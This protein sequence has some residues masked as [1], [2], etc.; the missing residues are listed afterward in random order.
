METKPS[1]E[2]QQRITNSFEERQA[3]YAREVKRDLELLRRTV[4]AA[5][6]RE[7]AKRLDR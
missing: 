3:L 4:K 2:Q 6:D 7:S 1:H 5:V